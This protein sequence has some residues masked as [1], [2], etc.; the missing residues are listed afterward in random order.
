LFRKY[1]VTLFYKKLRITIVVSFLC[2]SGPWTITVTVNCTCS[3]LK[4]K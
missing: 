4:V 3:P 1:L 2:E